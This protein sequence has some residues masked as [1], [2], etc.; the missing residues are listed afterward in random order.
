MSTITQPITVDE[1]ERMIEDG[2]IGEDDQVELLDGAVVPKMPKNPRRRVG[3]RKTAEALERVI[4]PVWHVAKEEAVVMK[5]R[6]KPEPDVAVIRAELKY[7]SSR[8]ATAAD[9]CLVVE[10]ADRSLADDQ[11]KKLAGYARA[12]IPVYWIINLRA[13][14]VE[15]YTGPEP[16]GQYGNHVDYRPGQ[17]IPVI[18][19]G[20]VVGQI[21]VAD[22]LP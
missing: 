13:G 17:A 2:T 11:G 15:V 1:Y 10:V 22:L 12:G 9:C 19:D 18:I 14:Q 8:D 16:A 21:A 20:Q 3:T 6:S 5:P 7:D 4:P